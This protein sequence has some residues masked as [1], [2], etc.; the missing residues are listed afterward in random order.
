VKPNFRDREKFTLEKVGGAIWPRL[1]GGGGGREIKGQW[2]WG[3]K[4]QGQGKLTGEVAVQ[5][6][7]DIVKCHGGSGSLSPPCN[8][9]EPE[10]VHVK[11]NMVRNNPGQSCSRIQ[12][13]VNM[14]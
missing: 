8:Y 12:H 7:G 14:C 3:T 6:D 5:A 4:C 10:S 1:S 11:R 9:L 13:L 2:A